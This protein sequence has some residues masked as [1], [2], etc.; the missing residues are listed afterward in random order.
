MSGFEY[1]VIGEADLDTV[2]IQRVGWVAPQ[3][4]ETPEA[5][6]DYLAEFKR[7]DHEAINPRIEQRPVG[8]WSAYV[9]GLAS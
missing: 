3:T 6:Q 1:R 4:F 8:S 5:A 9:E 2:P 7:T